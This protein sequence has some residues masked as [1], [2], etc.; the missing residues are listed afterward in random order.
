M[1]YFIFLLLHEWIRAR[2]VMHSN[3]TLVHVL[4]PRTL[5]PEHE[6][7]HEEKNVLPGDRVRTSAVWKKGS[8]MA[9]EERAAKLHLRF[10]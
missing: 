9:S 6:I 1:Y 2:L 4:L 8:T 10:C 3:V 7:T 5:F